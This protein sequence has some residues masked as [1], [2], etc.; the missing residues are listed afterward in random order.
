M[1]VNKHPLKIYRALGWKRHG[2]RSLYGHN[3]INGACEDCG[4]P[5]QEFKQRMGITDPRVK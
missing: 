3:F 1:Q 5:I 2:K 4:L